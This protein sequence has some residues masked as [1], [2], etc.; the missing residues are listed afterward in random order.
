M[1][2]TQG[3]GLAASVDYVPTKWKPPVWWVAAF[4]TCGVTVGIGIIEQPQRE[5]LGVTLIVIGVV[6]TA[7]CS[8]YWRVA[9][10]DL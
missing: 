4:V 5:A 1:S 2:L 6:L 10:R 8:R 7:A 9:R 3:A